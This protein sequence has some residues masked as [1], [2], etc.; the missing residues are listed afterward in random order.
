MAQISP[1][2]DRT[3]ALALIDDF[4]L[5]MTGKDIPGLEEA[6]D[7]IPAGTDPMVLEIGMG[8]GPPVTAGPT[9]FHFDNIVYDPVVR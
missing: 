1:A 9:S 2:A 6:R 5:E 4:S 3:A 7:A 8:I